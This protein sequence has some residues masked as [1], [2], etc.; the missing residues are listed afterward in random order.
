V[1]D[2]VGTREPRITDLSTLSPE[3]IKQRN[4]AFLIG[5]AQYDVLPYQTRDEL[6]ER[7]WRVRNGDLRR[8]LEDFPRDEPLVE[9]CALWVHALAGRHFFP[10]ANHRTAIALLRRLLR[11]NGIGAG[12]WPADRTAEAREA[13]HRIRASIEPVRLDTLYRRDDLYRVW[14][15][16]FE[17]VLND[18]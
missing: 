8:V 2:D 16:Y 14:R 18:E 5:D 7:I 11:V 17:R 10:D 13:S 3:D 4:T 6:R 12:A 9:Q 1:T 15:Q